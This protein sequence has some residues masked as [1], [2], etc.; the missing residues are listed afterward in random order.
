MKTAKAIPVLMYHH[1]SPNPGLVTVSPENFRAQM[2]QL[3][4]QGWHT[5]TLDD[6]ARFLAGEPMPKKSIVITFDD[7]YL[8]NWVHAH[9]VM[10]EYGL[11]GAIFIVTGWIGD[12]PP[13]PHAHTKVGA[14]GMAPLLPTPNHK[15]CKA[16]IAAG[17][18]DE[19]MLRWSEIEAMRAAGTFE[20]H[21]HTHTHT[22]WDLTEPDPESRHQ[23]LAADLTASRETLQARLGKA[24][25][26]LCW[27][28]G[29]YD[30]GYIVIAQANGFDHLY[31]TET[32]INVP[33]LRPARIGRIVTKN[34]DGAWL[35][36]RAQ[37][38]A[39]PWLGRCYR[40]LHS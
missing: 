29:Y 30:D 16:A 26:H 14:G 32:R 1:V 40:W 20:F 3:A 31:T 2:R 8:D 19:V 21:S 17:R 18:A 37:I 36:R 34:K 28:Q 7:G 38:Y 9:P 27:P 12:G 13:R 35:L 15:A 11:H 39:R 4:E 23:K 6:L 5:L 24:S 33:G 10:A 25:R 22:R